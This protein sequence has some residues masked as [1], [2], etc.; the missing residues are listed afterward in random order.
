MACRCSRDVRGAGGEAQM[1]LLRLLCGFRDM[2]PLCA[3]GSRRDVLP[4]LLALMLLVS[5]CAT[6]ALTDISF[7]GGQ[8]GAA[9]HSHLVFVVSTR[10]DED[11]GANEMRADGADY[12]LQILSVPPRHQAGHIERPM[13]GAADPAK[14]FTETSR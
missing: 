7:F 3:S 2:A 13:F 14:H 12:S 10:R 4:A 1:P 6:P 8:P 9:P 5:G 11:A